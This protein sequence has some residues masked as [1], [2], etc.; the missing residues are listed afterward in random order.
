MKERRQKDG[1]VAPFET[2]QKGLSSYRAQ[3]KEK[4]NLK[5]ET[6]DR[7]QMVKS[8]KARKN[9]LSDSGDATPCIQ[10]SYFWR[11]SRNAK[12]RPIVP[13]VA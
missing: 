2:L 4:R 8:L 3:V 9:M 7:Q 11:L 13:D 1:R 6:I 12:G 10:P 5:E